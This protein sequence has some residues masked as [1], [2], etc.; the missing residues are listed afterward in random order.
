[1]RRSGQE[2]ELPWHSETG[3]ECENESKIHCLKDGTRQLQHFVRR[4]TPVSVLQHSK[5]KQKEEE[6]DEWEDG[7][8]RARHAASAAYVGEL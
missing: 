6:E 2:Q 1:M 3:Q 7:E 5:Q 8:R 4:V